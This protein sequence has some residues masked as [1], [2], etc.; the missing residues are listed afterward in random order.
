MSVAWA[1]LWK[2]LVTE[3]RSRDR[4][5]AMGLFSILTVMVLHF[6]LPGAE[7]QAA[8]FPGLL[9]VAFVFAAVLGLNRSFAV[10]LE[11][12]A[13]SGLALAPV[14]RGS[15]FLGKAIA[16]FLLIGVVQAVTAVVFALAFD[17]DW[18]GAVPGLAAVFAL[19]TL[20][21][22]SVG[23]LLS[24]MAVRSRFRDLLLPIL[25][26]PFLFPLLS[27]AVRG[28][29]A[30]VSGQPIPFD[31]LQLLVVIDGIYLVVSYLSFEYILDE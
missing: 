15:I 10:E 2:D 12:D 23:T 7:R 8:D 4:L 28:T 30:V 6:A 31:A 17:L 24:A 29:H 26:P 9:W 18:S 3:W 16:T 20:G 13:L 27:G 22:A 25:L 1:I 19:G 21:I 14:D 11:N 5:V